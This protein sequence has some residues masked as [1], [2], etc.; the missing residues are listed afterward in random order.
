[1]DRIRTVEEVVQILDAITTADIRRVA[2]RVL[3][4][5]LQMAVIGPFDSDA[6]FRN[7]IE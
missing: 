5:P 2:Q 3:D 1:M 4:S 6:P 7:A